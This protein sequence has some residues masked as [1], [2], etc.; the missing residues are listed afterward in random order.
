[1]SQFGHSHDNTG[2]EPE[3]DEA[4]RQC[5]NPLEGSTSPELGS[6]VLEQPCLPKDY[7]RLQALIS[8]FEHLM[9]RCTDTRHPKV[10]E[11]VHANKAEPGF[12]R[13]ALAAVIREEER[14]ES[15]RTGH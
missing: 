11:F 10:I 13:L 6:D 1:M 12:T 15:A 5:S 4:A 3:R 14:L 9:R 8:R 2:T 7:T